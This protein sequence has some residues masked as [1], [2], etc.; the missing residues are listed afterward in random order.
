M[1]KIALVHLPEDSDDLNNEVTLSVEKSFGG[2]APSRQL[3][4]KPAHINTTGGVKKPS[5][6]RPRTVA[7]HELRRCQK[8]TELMIRKLFQ[9][10]MQEIAHEFRSDPR[11]QWAAVGEMQWRPAMFIA[12]IGERERKKS[13]VI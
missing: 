2:K 6:Y 7:L 9:R 13:R 3:V 1:F 10:F 8:S 12:L 11:F 5:R 4:T